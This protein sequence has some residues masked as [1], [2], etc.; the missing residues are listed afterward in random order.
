MSTTP[1]PLYTSIDDIRAANERLCHHFFSP[2]ARRFFRSRIL[3]GVIQG[4]L[5][6]TSERHSDRDPRLYTIRR[7]FPSG[8]VSTVGTFQGYRT[9]AQ[10]R[11]AARDLDLTALNSGEV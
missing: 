4:C 10:A 1:A 6:I 11:A 8:C 7:A 2:G 5:F 3:D 9:A